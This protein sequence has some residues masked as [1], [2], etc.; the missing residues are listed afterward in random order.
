VIEAGTTGKWYLVYFLDDEGFWDV[1][2]YY[3]DGVE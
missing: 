3:V 1:E 2:E